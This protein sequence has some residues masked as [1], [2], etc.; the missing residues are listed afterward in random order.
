MSHHLHCFSHRS[1]ICS[2]PKTFT[3]AIRQLL[4]SCLQ[5]AAEL[6]KM[7]QCVASLLVFSLPA[8][9]WISPSARERSLTLSAFFGSTSFRPQNVLD[10]SKSKIQEKELKE[11]NV[12]FKMAAEKRRLYPDVVA[13]AHLCTPLPKYCRCYSPWRRFL[14]LRE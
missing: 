5:I 1:N 3:T 2:P 8:P 12:D 7:C 11:D 4:G 9:K 6:W 14:L 10:L 13:H